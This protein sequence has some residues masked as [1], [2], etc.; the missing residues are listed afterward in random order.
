MVEKNWEPGGLLHYRRRNVARAARRVKQPA[1]PIRAGSPRHPGRKS[2][3]C[4][5]AVVG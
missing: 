4:R 3:L 2:L 1:V 5:G